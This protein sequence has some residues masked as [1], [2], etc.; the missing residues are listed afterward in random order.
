MNL[1]DP[2]RIHQ[3]DFDNIIY[4]KVKVTESKKIIFLKYNEKGKVKPFVIQCPSLL[5]I[6]EP[7]KIN[8]DYYDLEVPLIT[9]EKN[10][11]NDL[12]KFF[13]GLDQKIISDAKRNARTW[14]NEFSNKENIKYKKIIKE[15]DIYNE[16]LLKIKIIKNVDFETLLQIDNKKRLNI[17]DIPNNSWCKML[18][19]I[20]AVVFNFKNETFSIFIRPIILAFKE[21]NIYNYKFLEDSDSDSDS[22]K[23][24]IDIPDSEYNNVFLKQLGGNNSDKDD[25]TSSQI[26]IIHNDNNNIMSKNGETDLQY[27]N[28]LEDDSVINEEKIVEASPINQDVENKD[29]FSN[30]LEEKVIDLISKLDQIKELPDLSDTPTEKDEKEAEEA[31][32]EKDEKDEKDEEDEKENKEHNELEKPISNDVGGERSDKHSSTSSDTSN[33]SHTSSKI[34]LTD[35]S[36]D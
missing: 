25:L 1:Q 23:Q 28:K 31:E 3:I 15:S 7:I 9:Q 32:D 18:L 6:N 17:S 2:Y 30:Q 36:D 29:L 8:N 20:Y 26:K 34:D 11:S 14:F 16:G 19:E 21:K 35:S 22:K 5:N 33:T 12:I 10:K 13:E 24:I 4:Q 27:I